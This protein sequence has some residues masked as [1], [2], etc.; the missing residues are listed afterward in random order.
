MSRQSLRSCGMTSRRYSR[1][2]TIVL[3]SRTIVVLSAAKDLPLL[4][5]QHPHGDRQR[6]NVTHRMLGAMHQAT[7][8]R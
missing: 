5:L 7:H 3:H 1:G 2:M 8:Y 4:R 6:T